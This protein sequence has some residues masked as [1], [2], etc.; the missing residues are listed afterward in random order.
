MPLNKECKSIKKQLCDL[1]PGLTQ[2]HFNVAATDESGLM[3]G[4]HKI[5]DLIDILL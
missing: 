1:S 2:G 3:H 5:H 4:Y